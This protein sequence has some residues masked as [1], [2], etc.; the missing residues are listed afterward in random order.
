MN[1]MWITLESILPANSGGRLGV[2]KRLAQLSKTENIYLFYPYDDVAELGYVDELK[3][4]CKEVYPYDRKSNS[5]RAMLNLLKYPF[6]VASREIPELQADIKKCLK[7][8]NIDV[9]NVDFPHMCVNLLSMDLN[10]PII[11]NEHNIEWKVYKTIAKSQKNILKKIA[12]R[13]DS[14]RLRIYERQLLKSQDI[15]LF[16]FVSD[17]DME[18]MIKDNHLPKE[19]CCLIPVGADVRNVSQ[20]DKHKGHN[21]I[22]VGKMSY[23]P[24]VEAVKWFAEKIFP[25]INEKID[26]CFFYI[27]GKEPSYEVLNLQSDNIIV[28]G[29]VDSVD[30]YY[31]IADIVVIPLLNGG[32]VKIKLLEAISYKSHIISTSI[33]T[34]GTIYS[35]GNTITVC[36]EAV[37]F[38]NLCIDYLLNPDNYSTRLEIAYEIFRNNYTWESIGKKYIFSMRNV[39]KNGK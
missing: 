18:F 22:F 5:K 33:G 34:E 17:K 16:T 37:E 14:F 11:L 13:I 1:I 6:T 4:Y 7:S 28:T 30:E 9:I 21:I 26:D 15:S 3:K 24:N 19:K 35:D 39:L 12:Y 23:G 29:C 32:G 31:N 27:V 2:F 10:V 25:H 38:A 20:N 8:H 36:D